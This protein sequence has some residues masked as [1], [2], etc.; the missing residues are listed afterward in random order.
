M[1]TS[2]NLSQSQDPKSTRSQ[3]SQTQDASQKSQ[4]S[5]WSPNQ[6]LAT[7]MDAAG[8]PVPDPVIDSGKGKQSKE[9]DDDADV[10]DAMTADFD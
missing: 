7:H 5:S 6:L 3:G 1:P 2:K 9:F 4:E 10:F 8:H